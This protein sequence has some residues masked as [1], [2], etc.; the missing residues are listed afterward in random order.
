MRAV[1]IANN[2]NF[3][4]AEIKASIATLDKLG[5]LHTGA[6]HNRTAAKVPA[7]LERNGLRVGFL[8]RTSVYWSVNHEATDDSTGV[9]VIRGHTAYESPYY[10]SP[11]GYAP[12]NRPGVPPHIV[13]WANKACLQQMQEDIRV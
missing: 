10:K 9:A 7:I 3:G 2:I 8:Q 13:T 6:G 5:I 4:D 11:P 12:A 1:G